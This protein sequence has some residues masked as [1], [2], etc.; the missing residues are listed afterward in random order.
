VHFDLFWR[1]DA[2]A[3]ALGELI[4]GAHQRHVPTRARLAAVA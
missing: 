1:D 4:R 2:P 3:P